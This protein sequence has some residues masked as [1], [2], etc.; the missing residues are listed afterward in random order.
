M[1]T[2]MTDSARGTTKNLAILIASVFALFGPHFAFADYVAFQNKLPIPAPALTADPQYQMFGDDW[3]IEYVATSTITQFDRF[4][5]PL[6][7]YNGTAGGTI[8]LEIRST[9][10]TTGPV[11]ASSTLAVND[12]N[13]SPP[14][15]GCVTIGTVNAT[16]STFVLNNTIQ[17]VAG[18]TWWIRLRGV[19]LSGT[20]YNSMQ[21]VVNF[22]NNATVWQDGGSA[23][24]TYSGVTY[25]MAMTGRGLGTAPTSA[26]VYAT[27]SSPVVCT[28]FDVGC[29]ISTAV[30]W[31]FYPSIPLSTQ[32]GE[33]ASTT[34]GVVPFGYVS[35]LY[36]KLETYSNS[37]TTTLT[38][39]VELSPLLNW[40]GASFPTT[41][42]TVLSGAQLRSTL[43]PTMWSLTQNLLAGFLWFGFAF[44][45][46]RRSIHLL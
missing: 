40:L 41:T 26:S 45:V 38:I 37:A 8:E 16:T 7:R 43:G 29:Y 32:L 31:A 18:V 6:C 22:D 39:S 12:G 25:A 21:N 42:V 27:S 15:Q 35:D 20:V 4:D 13:V 44:Y 19:G 24:Y 23:P 5:I 10:S 3:V 2:N 14:S 17:T 33:L 11:I 1:R 34:S 30:A 36:T 46:Y 9:A 28:T